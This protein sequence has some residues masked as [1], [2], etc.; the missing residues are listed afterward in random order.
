MAGLFC[1]HGL[2]VFDLEVIIPGVN[3]LVTGQP[4][5]ER[6]L[7]PDSG[8]FSSPV[9][10]SGSPT[11]WFTKDNSARRH[12]PGMARLQ[13]QSHPSKVHC[14]EG[15]RVVLCPLPPCTSEGGMCGLS[16]VVA[17]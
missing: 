10:S 11:L 6:M 14:G 9:Y 7:L 13:S 17:L 16:L 3:V 1:L 8:F 5:G 2:S 12:D 4:L 15:G